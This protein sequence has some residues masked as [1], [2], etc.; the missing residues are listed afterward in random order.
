VSEIA[1]FDQVLVVNIVAIDRNSCAS[2]V[3]VNR[4]AISVID[5]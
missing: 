1:R 4:S 2:T 5:V 3:V